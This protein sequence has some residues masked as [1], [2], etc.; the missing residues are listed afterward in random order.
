MV[1]SVESILPAS[2]GKAEEWSKMGLETLKK[3]KEVNNKNEVLAATAKEIDAVNI[4]NLP[5]PEEVARHTKEF[6]T[7]RGWCLWR[8]RTLGGDII[9]VVRDE[10]VDGVP[11]GYPIYTIAELGA[12][13]GVSCTRHPEKGGICESTLRLIHEV[14]KIAGAAV[15]SVED[16]ERRN[17]AS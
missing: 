7:T 9:A 14:K 13:S 1:E 5:E 2:F 12:M 4:A 11:E 6:I 3:L 17:Y 15:V 8:C 10:N 16:T